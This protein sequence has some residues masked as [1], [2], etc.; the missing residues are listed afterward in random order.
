MYYYLYWCQ[1][2]YNLFVIHYITIFK[3]KIKIL[4][5]IVISLTLSSNLHAQKA[6]KKITILVEI[7]SVAA[8]LGFNLL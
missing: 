5:L 7:I 6:V 1:H 4:L 3:M 8:G 2:F